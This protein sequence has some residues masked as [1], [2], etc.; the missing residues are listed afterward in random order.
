MNKASAVI[1]EMPQE[2][3]G[4]G[5][6]R[7]DPRASKQSSP[8]PHGWR[9]W[10]LPEPSPRVSHR[11]HLF[12]TNETGPCTCGVVSGGWQRPI[13]RVL[14]RGWSRGLVCPAQAGNP[15]SGRGAGAQP[16]PRVHTGGSG[17]RAPQ[18]RGWP[19][20][21]VQSQTLRREGQPHE[22]A[23]DCCVNSSALKGGKQLH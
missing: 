9:G 7:E 14:C 10:E 15:D 8:R 11:T 3:P 17:T 5:V 18:Q 22:P 12:P 16:E 4:A 13:A 19:E 21:T 1:T 20:P 6:C 2:H 23:L